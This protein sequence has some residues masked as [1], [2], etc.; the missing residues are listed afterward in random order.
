M[1]LLSR[2]RTPPAA[3]ADLAEMDFPRP[4]GAGAR[5]SRAP[6]RLPDEPAISGI[7]ADAVSVGPLTV[8]AASLVGPGHRCAEPAQHRQDAYRLGRDPDRRHLL[9]AV[10]DG[11]SDSSR[12]HLGANVAVTALIGRLRADLAGGAPLDGPSLFLDA[13]RQMSGMAAQQRVTENDVRAAALAA[14]VP[15]EPAPD[16]SRLVWLAWVADVGAW[17]RSD[18]GWTRLVGADKEGLDLDVLTEFLPFHPDRARTAW[19]TVQRGAVLAFATDG[20]GDVLAGGA[21]P[22]FAERWA[23]P[24]H[25]ASFVADVGFDARGQ[26]DDRTA[27]VVWCDR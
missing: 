15:V 24:P 19:V 12:S 4:L 6:W 14:V 3:P 1:G 18:A 23:G 9:V 27:V 10:A 2:R 8:R 11:M 20:V 21:A 26:L 7:A 25:V 17:L 5:Q 13:A 16:G 22:W